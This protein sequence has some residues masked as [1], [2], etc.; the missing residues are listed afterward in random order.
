MLKKR[1][2][3]FQN[4]GIAGKATTVTLTSHPIWATVHAQNAPLSIQLLTSVLKKAVGDGP[5]IWDPGIHVADPDEAPGSW[6]LPD[7]V[8]AYCSLLGEP[9]DG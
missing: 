4:C 3:G 5:S 2:R 8:L 7:P 1:K 9:V 6:F